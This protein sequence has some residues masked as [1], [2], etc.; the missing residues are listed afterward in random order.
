MKQIK[1]IPMELYPQFITID[2]L[3]IKYIG[4]VYISHC[5]YLTEYDDKSATITIVT[6]EHLALRL[7]TA[8]A[9][10]HRLDYPCSIK[11]EESC[12]A[13]VEWKTMIHG[14]ERMY[15]NDN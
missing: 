12:Q 14:M 3:L 10:L 5:I 6:G 11:F 8:I 15:L 13:T 1:D 2:R 7:S 4:D 9:A